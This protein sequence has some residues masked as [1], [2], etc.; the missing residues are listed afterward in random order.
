MHLDI[1][2]DLAYASHAD[3]LLQT[4]SEVCACGAACLLGG[5]SQQ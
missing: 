3:R 5:V 1:V 2:V 4:L